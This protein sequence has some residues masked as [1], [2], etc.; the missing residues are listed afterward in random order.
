MPNILHSCS[1]LFESY[2]K[3]VSANPQTVGDLET[4]LKWASY[5]VSGEFNR[6]LIAI[7]SLTMW[8]FNNN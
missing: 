8:Q 6:L 3:W 1:D 4:T 5:F 7:N 2:K